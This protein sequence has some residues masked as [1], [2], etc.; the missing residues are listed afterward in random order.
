MIDSLFLVLIQLYLLEGLIL[1]IEINYDSESYI[2]KLI[3]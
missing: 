3:I 2:T 1:L